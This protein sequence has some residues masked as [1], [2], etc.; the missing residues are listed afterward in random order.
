MILTS[1]LLSSLWLCAQAHAAAS[2]SPS[3]HRVPSTIDRLEPFRP[4]AKPGDPRKGTKNLRLAIMGAPGSG[5]GTQSKRIAID[6]GVKHI[7]SGDLLREYARTD[8][9]VAGYIARGELVPFPIVMKVMKDRLSKPDVQASG[10]ILDGF[11][12]RLEDAIALLE[13]LGELGTPLDAVVRLEVPEEELR[14]RVLGR[15]REDD[16]EEVFRNRMRVY[17]EQTEPVFSYL[18][19]KVNFLTPDV[20]VPDPD[21][22]YRNVKAAL[23]AYLAA[24]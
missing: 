21:A 3:P 10:F 12:R 16:T 13:I 2:F 11:P 9:E 5:K 22:A 1:A 18:Q 19:G 6:F 15:G 8:A 23:D 20:T 14:R 4:L 7:S 24:R 17:R